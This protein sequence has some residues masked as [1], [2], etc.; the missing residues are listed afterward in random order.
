MRKQFLFLGLIPALFFQVVG[1]YLYF[2]LLTGTLWASTAYMITKG[3]VLFWPMLWFVLGYRCFFEKGE[4]SDKKTSL[5]WG[6][7]SGVFILVVM[8]GLFAL[9]RDFF[10]DS[11]P[12]IEEKLFDYK[13]TTP[14]IYLVVFILYSLFH[15]GVEEYFWRWFLF[16]GLKKY[17]TPLIAGVVSSIGFGLHHYLVIGQ[18]LPWHMMLLLGTC[19]VVG[20]GWWCFV[21]HKTKSL[22]GAW[23]SHV[24]VD[25]GVFGI[26]YCILWG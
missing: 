4:K 8:L 17:C 22:L 19:V 9:L 6:I 26:G 24:F 12:M 2:D 3:L 10:V 20:G 5:L 13:I 23:I 16:G 25:L 15:A 18:Y 11:K 14:Q 1:S 7:G 21:Y